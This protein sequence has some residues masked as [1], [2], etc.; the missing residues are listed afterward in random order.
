MARALPPKAAYDLYFQ[1]T[2]SPP[3][4]FN[5]RRKQYCKK[6]TQ[7]TQLVSRFSEH[8]SSIKSVWWDLKNPEKMC[9]WPIR[10]KLGSFHCVLVFEELF[11][12]PSKCECGCFRRRKDWKL[13]LNGISKAY[14]AKNKL[15]WKFTSFMTM[16]KNLLHKELLLVLEEFWELFKIQ[17][18]SIKTLGND[19][20]RLQ[21]IWRKKV[22][23]ETLLPT[24]E[25]SEADWLLLLP[26]NV[27]PLKL[28]R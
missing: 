6:L 7:E 19:R 10:Q 24:L 25:K 15:Q 20:I 13:V 4:Y 17:Q 8:S 26:N 9:P 16:R 5:Y 3:N 14:L 28:I 21:L 27:Q 11:Y 18:P 22:L 23:M 2:T 1:L 12:I